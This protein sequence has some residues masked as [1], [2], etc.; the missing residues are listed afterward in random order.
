MHVYIYIYTHINTYMYM[1]I[2]QSVAYDSLWPDGLQPTRLPCPWNSLGKNTGVFC[3]FTQYQ[4]GQPFPSTVNLPNPGIELRS[5]ALQADFLPS[6]SPGKLFMHLY[7]LI[8]SLQ[9]IMKMFSYYRIFFLGWFQFF[10]CQEQ[11][12]NEQVCGQILVQISAYLL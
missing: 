2:C 6:G 3:I 4:S 8:F 12:Y 7:I 9:D 10:Y 5:P 1:H 11:Q